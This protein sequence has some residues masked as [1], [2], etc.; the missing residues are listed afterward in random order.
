ME[1]WLESLRPGFGAYAHVF[2]SFGMLQVEDLSE[3]DASMLTE[4]KEHMRQSSVPPFQSGIILREL[5]RKVVQNSPAAGASS[6][7]NEP[8]EIPRGEPVLHS[9][10]LTPVLGR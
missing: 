9:Q 8:K 4:L 6:P 5:E 7:A 1:S 2:L 3:F 10:I